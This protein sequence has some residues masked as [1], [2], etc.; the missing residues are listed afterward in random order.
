VPVR[1]AGKGLGGWS[2]ITFT[3]NH[4]T[5]A[6]RATFN[7]AAQNMEL[8]FNCAAIMTRLPVGSLILGFSTISDAL[9]LDGFD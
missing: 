7:I 6:N 2:I 5:A 8:A 4:L 9:A 1:R 3:S